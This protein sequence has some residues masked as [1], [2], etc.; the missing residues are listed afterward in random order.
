MII[1]EVE[2]LKASTEDWARLTSE[3]RQEH[4]GRMKEAVMYAT[5]RNVL[6]LRTVHSLEFITRDITK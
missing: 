5:N 6:A 4:E 2:D 1:K 3:Q